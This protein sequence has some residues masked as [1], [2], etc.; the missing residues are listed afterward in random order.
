MQF[1]FSPSKLLT[2][3]ILF[4]IKELSKQVCEST[5]TELK[6]YKKEFDFVFS[7]FL[8]T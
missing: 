1:R 7:I 8:K 2:L 3:S 4:F 6:Q 5:W